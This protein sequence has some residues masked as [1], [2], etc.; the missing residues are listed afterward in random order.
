MITKSLM[1]IPRDIQSQGQQ[2]AVDSGLNNGTIAEL[3][4]GVVATI[5]AILTL[6]KTW[7]CWKSWKE[8]VRTL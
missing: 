8:S 2:G 1:L 3:V 6:F 4:I 5:V 7:K